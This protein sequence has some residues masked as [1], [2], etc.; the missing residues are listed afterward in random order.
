MNDLE[1]TELFSGLSEKYPSLYDLE[2]EM[3]KW[4]GSEGENP[5]P[6]EHIFSGG[7][8][9]RQMLG[10]AG[11]LAIGKRHRYETC[12][13]LLAGEVSIYMGSDKPAR[14]I[15][16]PFQWTSPPMTKKLVY[17]HEDSIFVNIHPTKETDL[18]KIE[19]HFII[20][21][22]EYLKLPEG[23]NK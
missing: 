4:P 12:N 17:F 15:K 13:M 3:A 9:I 14:R 18:A 2:M 11:T 22:K 20:P 1:V 7:V 8:Y 10:P 23:E 16:A 21:E 6:L 5:F 19:N